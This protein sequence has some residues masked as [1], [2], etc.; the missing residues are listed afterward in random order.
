MTEKKTLIFV[1]DN[2]K[3]GGAE[4]LLIGIL[5]RLSAHYRIIL[6][7]LSGHKEFSAAQLQYCTHLSLGFRG[8][9]S[10]LTAVYRLSVIIKKY[11]PALIHAH[12]TLSSQIARMANRGRFPMAISLHSMLYSNVFSKSKPLLLMEKMLFKKRDALIAVSREA[13]MEY[14]THIGK[15]DQQYVLHNYIADAFLQMQKDGIAANQSAELKLVA[16]GNIRRV[17]NYEFLLKAIA[18]ANT[19]AISLDIYGAADADYLAELQNDVQQHH[20]NVSFKGAVA[21][22]HRVLPGYDAFIMASKHEGFGIAV[23]E[24]MAVGL[25]VLLSDIPVFRSITQNKALFFNLDDTNSLVQL[26]T[27]ITSNKKMLSQPAI[28]GSKWVKENY[29]CD[30]YVQKLLHIYADIQQ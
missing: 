12:L 1:I 7:T 11:R 30:I 2:L 22:V 3:R 28:D 5:P 16:V 20:L 19:A 8:K 18:A 14:Q 24:A 25:P 13:L 26:L 23:V 29:T 9:L 10:L 17:K 15:A 27:Q 4:T 6:V 21:D